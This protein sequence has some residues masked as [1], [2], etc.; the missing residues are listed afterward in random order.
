MIMFMCMYREVGA[1]SGDGGD[2]LE[3]E[4]EARRRSQTLEGIISCRENSPLC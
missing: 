4:E 3:E 2:M 1:D